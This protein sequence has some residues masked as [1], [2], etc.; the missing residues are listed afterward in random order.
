MKKSLVSVIVFLFIV[1]LVHAQWDRGGSIDYDDDE[2]WTIQRVGFDLAAGAVIAAVGYILMQIK[3][4]S[5]LGKFLVGVGAFLGIGAV[6]IYLL[7]IIGMILSA[8]LSFAIKAGIVIGAILLV[9]WIL[10]GIY[11]WIKKGFS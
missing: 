11:E 8:T 4:I 6:I 5:G 3:S 10:R 7:Q 9:L 1:K 2:A